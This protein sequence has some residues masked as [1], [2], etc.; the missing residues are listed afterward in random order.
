[1]TMKTLLLPTMPDADEP[2]RKYWLPALVLW[3]VTGAIA[4]TP[5]LVAKLTAPQRKKRADAADLRTRQEALT[6]KA[7]ADAEA[8]FQQKLEGEPDPAKRA[9]MVEAREAARLTVRQVQQ[10]QAKAASKALRSKLGDQAGAAA[11]LLVVGGPLIWSLAR[12]WIPLGAELL[13][14][15]WWLAALMH[16]PTP[17]AMAVAAA[18]AA[19]RD[20]KD[21]DD[22]ADDADEEEH[23]DDQADDDLDQESAD[24]ED[25]ADEDDS[26]PAPQPLT[27]AELATT[28]EHMVAI[29]ATTDGGAGNV[30]LPE[31]LA[32]LQHFGHYQGAD[33][34][35]F[36]AAV[37]AAG[38][39]P[40]P[41]VGVVIG[42]R[43]KTSPGWSM[44]YLRD[45]LGRTPSLPPRPAVDHT[46]AQ[47]A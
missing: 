2:H 35:E 43:R 6:A 32:T 34:R 45:L 44:A 26:A 11:L 7:A 42:D 33:T 30:I 19:K 4:G 39:P 36:G 29:R 46:P 15:A 28:I 21:S 47:A 5:P 31:A 22:Q 25:Q 14:I 40:K 23:G 17:T 16:A 3:P 12:P 18:A 37:R 13:A 1:M 41:S 24:D 38:L 27:P 20:R 10:E 9:A 8:A